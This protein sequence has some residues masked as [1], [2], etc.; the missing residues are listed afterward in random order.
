MLRAMG[1]EYPMVS[2]Y[3]PKPRYYKNSRHIPALFLTGAAVIFITTKRNLCIRSYALLIEVYNA[4]QQKRGGI[5]VGRPLLTMIERVPHRL[6]SHCQIINQIPQ[7]EDRARLS[8]T[9]D[10][11][12]G[13]QRWFCIQHCLI[14]LSHITFY[15]WPHFQPIIHDFIYSISQFWL[16]LFL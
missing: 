15:L 1:D 11:L 5:L 8:A 12:H 10:R 13:T 4:S 16:Q 3:S 14:C 9:K 2:K 7:M 6:L